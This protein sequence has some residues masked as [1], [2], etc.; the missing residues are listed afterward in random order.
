MIDRITGNQADLKVN[1]L[2]DLLL[3]REGFRTYHQRKPHTIVE[4]FPTHD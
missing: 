2:I 4:R 1:S 3:G